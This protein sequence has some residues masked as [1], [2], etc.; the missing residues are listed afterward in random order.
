MWWIFQ[1]LTVRASVQFF[2]GE[3][4]MQRGRETFAVWHW[5]QSFV[6]LLLSGSYWLWRGGVTNFRWKPLPFRPNSRGLKNAC[7]SFS[8]T[9]RGKQNQQ[10]F[11]HISVP[12]IY[13]ITHKIEWDFYG[14][15]LGDNLPNLKHHALQFYCSNLGFICLDFVFHWL[16]IITLPNYNQNNW[17]N[18]SLYC[19]KDSKLLGHLRLFDL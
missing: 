2:S 15:C 9:P 14:H 10:T 8:N 5:H 4:E 3:M 19:F 16:N 12:L 11:V 6:V 17:L 18:W 1:E 7:G 13:W